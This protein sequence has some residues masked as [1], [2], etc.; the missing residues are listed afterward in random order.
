MA[1]L[2]TEHAGAIGILLVLQALQIRFGPSSFPVTIWIDNA[3][4]LDRAK[5]RKVGDNIKDHLVLDYD[6]WQA[7]NSLQALI[8]TPIRWEKVDSHIEEKTYKDGATPKGDQYS[9]RLNK[10]V[11]EWAGLTRQGNVGKCQQ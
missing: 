11:D 6:L 3:E 7:M 8:H 5:N 9:I 4:V 1:S 2:R 10:V